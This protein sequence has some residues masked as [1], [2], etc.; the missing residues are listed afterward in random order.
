[1]LTQEQVLS[2]VKAGRGS[3]ALDG[4]DFHRLVEFFPVEQWELFGASLKE[5]CTPAPVRPWTEDEI[6]KHLAG[7]VEFA[8]EK[9]LGK[10]GISAS[11]MFSVLKMW[12][13]VL[14]DDLQHF[15]EDSYAQYG[16][17]LIKAVA[18]KYGFPNEIG[19][20][21]GDESEYSTYG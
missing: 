1:M 19:D 20:D 15:S 18:L 9:A 14:E 4:R 17:P 8:F 5:G 10:R 11:M 16:L 7:D 3:E 13:W 2:A 21:D 12:M 6:K